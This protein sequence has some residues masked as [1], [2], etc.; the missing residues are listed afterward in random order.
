MLKGTLHALC[1]PRAAGNPPAVLLEKLFI[2]LSHLRNSARPLRR[3]CV[4]A[5]ATVFATQLGVAAATAAAEPGPA[6]AV[7]AEGG[8]EARQTN[9]ASNGPALWSLR[10][11]VKPSLPVVVRTEW[12]RQAIDQFVLA[13]LEKQGWEPAPDIDPRR[14]ARR[15]YFDL[16]GLPPAPEQV[17]QFVNDPSPQAY[18]A[19]VDRLLADP[20]YGERWG[21]HWLDVV[22]FAETNGYERDAPKPFAWQYRDWVIRAFNED[23]PYDRFVLEQ[24]AGDELPDASEQT[25][26]ATGFLRVGTFDD[27]PND[28]LQYRFEQL[29]DLM[30]TTGTA[31][32]ALTLK[33]ARCHDHKFDAIPQQDYY[34]LL[35]FFVSGKPAEG[36]VLAFTDQGPQAPPVRLLKSGDPRH[37]QDVVPP[38]FLTLLPSVYRQVEPPPAG[39][40]TTRWRTQLARWIA[41]PHNPLTAR[42]MVNRVWQ[43]HFGQGISR[44]PDNFGLLGD[45]PSH[46]ELLDWLAA[47]FM[48]HGW[49]LKRLHRTVVL[50]RTYRMDS[51]HPRGAEYAQ[52]DPENR[53]LWRMNRRRLEAEAVRD[54]M[55]AVSGE[56]SRRVGGPSYYPPIPAEALEGLSRK[57]AAWGTSP[58]E[59]LGRR[60]IY[61]FTQRSLLVPLLTSFDFPD[62]TQPCCQRNVS[63]VAQQALALLNNE[64]VIEQSRQFA[65]RVQHERP[66]ELAAQVARAWLVALGRAPATAELH[67]ALE[68]IARQSE[69]FA[70]SLPPHAPVDELALASLCQVLFNTN[71]FMFVD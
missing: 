17:E 19:L 48:E 21:R 9:A 30:H 47:D 6:Q 66:G 4:W 18:E 13:R 65:R 44:T 71:E 64:F 37:E 56:L 69:R 36:E 22:R 31:F 54:A 59:E 24:L 57:E 15:V 53:L 27:E 14:L 11:V 55:L 61:I 50:S 70:Q 16:W 5:A 38:G 43:H 35:N 32:L 28:P 63:I 68:H 52:R 67:A 62:T 1:L 12:P 8:V 2:M 7:A 58:P 34:A 33:C 40:A 51:V 29:D 39:A 26:T 25:L 49:Q 41:D 46:P 23:M 3:V 42:V 60:S 20:R 10:P 45:E